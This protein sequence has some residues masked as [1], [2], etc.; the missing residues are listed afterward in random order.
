MGEHAG[1]GEAGGRQSVQSIEDVIWCGLVDEDSVDPISDRVE[2][3]S[4]SPGNDRATEGA[5]LRDGK[6]EILLGYGHEGR[7]VGV[8]PAQLRIGEVLQPDDV[9]GPSAR[10]QAAHDHQ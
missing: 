3:A 1:P 7:A 6:T 8:D 9:A 10:G 5:D 2:V 4:G